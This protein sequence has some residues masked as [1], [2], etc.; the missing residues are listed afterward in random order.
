MNKNNL[1]KIKIYFLAITIM[2]VVLLV[3]GINVLRGN[4]YLQEKYVAMKMQ[5][6]GFQG[7][8]IIDDI[9]GN[10]WS[11]LVDHSYADTTTLHS[12]KAQYVPVLLYHGIITDSDWKPD[13]VNVSQEDFRDQMVA[14]KAAGYQ[15][16]SLA[17]FDA[18]MK[19]EKSLPEKS[20]LIT[21]DDARVDSYY[22]GDSILKMVGFRA[23]MFVITG[24][25]L[26]VEKEN[27]EFHL[28]EDE[29]K[30]MME[31]GRW[32]IGSHTKNGHGNIKIDASGKEG[33][34]LSNKMWLDGENRL[35]TEEEYLKR[36]KDDL[37]GSKKDLKDKLGV[38]AQSFAYPFGDYGHNTSNYPESQ[39]IISDIINE[40]FDFSFRQGGNSDYPGNYPGNGFRRIKRTDISSPLT[41]TDLILLLSGS[42]EKSLPY[43]DSFFRNKGWL[44]GWGSSHLLEGLFITGATQEEDSSMTFLDG[45]ALWE[46]YQMTSSLELVKGNS[47]AVVARFNNGN[48][49]AS[50]DFSDDS[51]SLNQRVR[52]EEK[53]IAESDKAYPINPGQLLS[54][55]V[56]VRGDQASCY[57][58]GQKIV[59]GKISSELNNGGIGFKTWN[60]KVFNSSLLVKSVDVKN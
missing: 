28:S 30:K 2:M 55:G 3:T 41:P 37:E 21:F 51:V 22:N 43:A 57:L 13:G 1:R 12:G 39:K 5:Y 23:T 15:S 44:D 58:N 52:G 35:E 20:V 56:E 33:H 25:S 31:S 46:D 10:F 54:V 26:G 4:Y 16:V 50:C 9:D 38:D 29:L 45:A 14:M 49:Y 11:N 7:Q 53:T 47:F 19:G 18:F 27:H 36:I 24:R 42:Q 40:A 48:N 8:N 59:S 60:A 34:F 17:D 32:D 6:A